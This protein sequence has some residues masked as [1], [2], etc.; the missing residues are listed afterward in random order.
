M[1]T[2]TIT[3]TT[4]ATCTTIQ[5]PQGNGASAGTPTDA[6]GRKLQQN[7]SLYGNTD[8]RAEATFK[9]VDV[10]GSGGIDKS[11]FALAAKAVG[12]SVEAE[13]LEEDFKEYDADKNGTIDQAEFLKFFR[14]KQLAFYDEDAAAVD[15]LS[16]EG[17][18]SL[19]P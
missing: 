3:S 19:I 7:F 10:D 5:C 11:E 15:K 6:T 2:C 8:S 18:K 1:T 4:L 16:A 17:L 9:T 13:E 14:E 12:L